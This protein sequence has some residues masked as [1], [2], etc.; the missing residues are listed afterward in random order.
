M[1]L[2]STGGVLGI[3][4]GVGIGRTITYYTEM[5]TIYSAWSIALALAI[6][7]ITGVIWA[8]IR[9]TRPR[10]GTR[11]QEIAPNDVRA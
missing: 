11:L 8:H 1:F 2:T 6:S 4:L 5:P 3:M 9:P 7:S 10:G